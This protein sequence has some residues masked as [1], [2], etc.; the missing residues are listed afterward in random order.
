MNGL[1]TR[2][3]RNHRRIRHHSARRVRSRL[4]VERIGRTSPFASTRKDS[5]FAGELGLCGVAPKRKTT[6]EYIRCT[7]KKEARICSG[8][9][10]G[11]QPELSDHFRLRLFGRPPVRLQAPGSS[12]DGYSLIPTAP[13]RVP[14]SS[15]PARSGS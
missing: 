5:P 14:H 8:N 11:E 3:A 2:R 9:L 12:R 7:L 15:R 4:Q 1:L 13:P 6:T 10:R